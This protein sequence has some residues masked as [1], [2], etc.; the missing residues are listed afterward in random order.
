MVPRH[1]CG[2]GGR[3][4]FCGTRTGGVGRW[5]RVD[6]SGWTGR[7]MTPSAGS[8]TQECSPARAR[9]PVSAARAASTAVHV[10]E[11]GVVDAVGT[12]DVTPERHLGSVLRSQVA[13][14]Q[15]GGRLRERLGG[16]AAD[17]TAAVAGVAVG[18]SVEHGE[19]GAHPAVE[20]VVAGIGRRRVGGDAERPQ[21]PLAGAAL[22]GC[23]PGWRRVDADHRGV[24]LV[25]QPTDVGRSRLPDHLDD[26]PIGVQ[27]HHVEAL[28]GLGDV[29]PEGDVHQGQSSD[30]S[31]E[32]RA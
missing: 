13:R 20:G 16:G 30:R 24:E 29:D 25:G 1:G 27:R 8:P 15:D 23:C 7:R 26:P 9:T 11:A 28:A 21:R 31:S 12:E 14:V 4:G 10:A 32:A 22:A 5:S 2:L 19:P 17:V 6:G 18:D 3:I